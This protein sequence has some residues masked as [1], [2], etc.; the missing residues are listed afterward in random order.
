MR[1]MSDDRIQF[2][3][4]VASPDS[5]Q[6]APPWLLLIV[7]DD[8]SVHRATRFA[9]DDFLFEDRGLEILSAYSA[10]QARRIMTDEADIAVLLLD[11]VMESE[12]IGLEL[13][14]WIRSEQLNDRVRI[15]LRT[16]Q[17]GYAPEL[18]VIRDYD[19]NDYKEKSGMTA[20]KLVTTVFSALRSFRDI[21]RLEQQ[22]FS[23]RQALTSAE[24]ANRVKS[25]FISHISHELRT[26]LNGILGMSE[27]IAT[28]ALGPIGN[29]RYKE[30]A[31]D[32]ITS[33]RHLQSLLDQ[34]MA[35]ADKGGSS[36]LD[37]QYFDLQEL[38]SEFFE[39]E[40]KTNAR[41]VGQG[42]QEKSSS[43]KGRLMLRADRQAVRT[44][45]TNLVSNAFAHNPP[46]CAVRVTARRL[47]GDGLVLA[48]SDEGTG[49][50]P[51]IVRRLGEPFNRENDPY[52]ASQGGLGL[53]LVTTK[54][55]IMRHGGDMT[56]ESSP[57]GGT[58][59]RLLF[60]ADSL[61]PEKESEQNA[62]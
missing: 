52:V 46:N 13:V 16:G 30:Y 25:D 61:L 53:G 26:P 49:I 62:G 47:R 29:P 57:Q 6:A 22:T 15:V 45:L 18:K 17:P 39:Q 36:T 1:Q 2:I 35:F 28:E 42:G 54:Q 21:V 59:V 56:I 10:E 60:P 40:A 38:I 3:E 55:L 48:V 12:Y 7:D 31:W 37:L 20:E 50:D 14:R 5:R 27:M 58:T 34:V 32:I 41:V 33:G 11:V 23:L 8:E 9:L 4:D 24:S 43:S 19:I 51:G 44:M